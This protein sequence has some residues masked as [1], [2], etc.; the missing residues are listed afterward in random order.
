[1]HHRLEP[2]PP[3]GREPRGPAVRAAGGGPDLDGRRHVYPH[4][5]G[6]AVPGGGGG[7][8]LAPDRRLVAHIIELCTLVYPQKYGKPDPTAKGSAK[9]GTWAGLA[10]EVEHWGRWVL[11]RV[12]AEIGDLY[13]PIPDPK[14]PG[15]EVAAEPQ[16]FLS[17]ANPL[18]GR[19]KGPGRYLT[20]VA[21][22][23]TRTVKC[24]DPS[25]GAVVPLVKQT[26]LCKKSGRYA[27]MKLVPK[28]VR[29]Q[30]QP[31]KVRFE[32]VEATTEGG[33]GFDPAAFSKGGNATCPF[34]GAV[35]D[36]SYVMS[37]G[38]TK[39]IGQQLMAVACSRTGSQGKVYLS[40]DS[41]TGIEPDATEVAQ[42]IEQFSQRIGQPPPGEPINP[43]RPSPNS[44]GL[45]AVTRH[46]LTTFG[47][48]FTARQTACLMA[49]VAASRDAGALMG[50]RGLDSDR[51]ACLIAYLG[52]MVDKLADF[53]STQCCWNYTGGRGVGHAFTRHALSMTWDYAETHP[54]NP[55]GASWPA[56]IE[57][58]PA[59]IG[60]LTFQSPQAHVL[61]GSATRFDLPASSIDAAVTDP[62]YYDN[63]PTPTR[64]II[65]MS[66]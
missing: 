2:R 44:R 27:A 1:M 47:D 4:P 65:F 62:P 24:K 57:D 51:Q 49:F 32:V 15:E 60:L 3:R 35:A 50:E 52:M 18:Q 53:N 61:R 5:P 56:I 48:L 10:A 9:D 63:V 20:P 28:G 42:R 37:Q 64:L 14:A 25:C 59:A 31:K 22:L 45:S 12:K 34:C 41:L 19:L 6:V 39:L 23:W 29:G 17:F 38:E 8:A 40:A 33:L 21:Y 54:F 7:P 30:S 36:S 26:W 43:M 13:P 11:E 66:G 16:Q 46:G 58:I 55:A